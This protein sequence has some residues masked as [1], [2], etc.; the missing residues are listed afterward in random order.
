MKKLVVCF[1]LTII[2]I[3]CKERKE[4]NA[5][6]QGSWQCVA[7]SGE[8]QSYSASTIKGIKMLFEG[9]DYL[10]ITG[11]FE[12]KGRFSIEGKKIWF[13]A[14]TRLEKSMMINQ[15]T[16]DTLALGMNDRGFERIMTF[17]KVNE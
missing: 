5:L 3:G 8:M 13:I 9:N 10:Y 17:V 15:L 14:D 16:A 11:G 6:L 1:L 7:V 12:E 2:L 4:K